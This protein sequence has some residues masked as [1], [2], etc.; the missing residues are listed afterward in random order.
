VRLH[1]YQH[2]GAQHLAERNVAALLDDMGLGKSAMAVTAADL[3]A[4][5]N[6]LIICP[7][8][9]RLTWQKEVLEW[10]TLRRSVQI[11]NSAADA[12][13]LR[14]DAVII[15]Y[16]LV[17]KA[18]AALRER[19]FDVLILDE[20]QN[21]KSIQAERTKAI[22]GKGGLVSSVRRVWLLSGTI[23]PNNPSEWYP[24]YRCLF[25]GKLPFR[26]F[27]DRYCVVKQ[28]PFGEQIVGANVQ[29]LAELAA[30][31]SPYIL[32]RRQQD[33]LKEL[34]PLRFVHVPLRPT[35]VPLQPDL[36]VEELAILGRS[37]AGEN[38]AVAEQMKLATLR[39]WT[40]IAKTP[41]VI[42]HIESVLEGPQKA[43]AFGYHTEVL[44]SIYKAFAPIA[45]LIDGSTPQKR[46]QELLDAFQGADKPRLLILQITVGGTAITLHRAHHVV[47]AE[48]TWT[49]S[50][51]VQAAKRCHRLG[52]ASSVLAQII[53][54][55]GSIDERVNGVVMRKA[56]ELAAF[57][58][59]ITS[60]VA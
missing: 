30:H 44:L 31:L 8:I 59:L 56:N 24:P 60:K 54:L 12:K 9:A 41:A 15:S 6:I 26:E 34:P 37:E 55:S 47:F 53:S 27:R 43:V 48:V 32:Q 58:T 39:R 19:Q 5:V 57:E 38:V 52:Q 25:G 33:V 4:A 45:G 13:N 20:A 23:A 46:R 29:R 51:I 40:G 17:A 11:I 36:S 49:P 7:A 42:E 10:Q 14:G 1:G 28:T 2:G 16:A 3:I 21:A 22:Y 35:Q 18:L 50:D